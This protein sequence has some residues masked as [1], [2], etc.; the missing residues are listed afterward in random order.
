MGPQEAED[1]LKSLRLQAA[2]L[3]GGEDEITGNVSTT[4]P[5]IEASL[6]ECKSNT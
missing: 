4:F 6:R 5:K 1:V 3:T 2:L